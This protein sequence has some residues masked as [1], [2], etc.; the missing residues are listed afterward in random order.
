MRKRSHLQLGNR[1]HFVRASGRGEAKLCGCERDVF[2]YAG[3]A[4]MKCGC[5]SA[6][7]FG[8]FC[9]YVHVVEGF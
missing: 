8:C 7:V 1:F 9:C 6:F 4:C 2:L 5:S 3:D